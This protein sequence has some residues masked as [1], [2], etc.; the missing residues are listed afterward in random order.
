MGHY[1]PYA[2]GS[3]CP[4]PCL[5]HERPD[6]TDLLNQFSEKTCDLLRENERLRREMELTGSRL[7]LVDYWLEQAEEAVK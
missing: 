1:W 2:E 3:W 4:Y 7:A 6:V 5:E